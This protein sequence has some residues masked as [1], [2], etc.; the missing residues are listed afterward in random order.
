M[1]GRKAGWLS[2]LLVAI[3]VLAGCGSGGGAGRGEQARTEWTLT[4]TDYQFSPA[5]VVVP[6]GQT[7]TI[8]LVNNSKLNQPHEFMVGRQV[9]KGGAGDSRPVGYETD[10]FADISVEVA[11]GQGLS[12]LMAGQALVTGAAATPFLQAGMTMGGDMGPSMGASETGHAAEE[13]E[14]GHA[15]E[16]AEH[17]ME[18]AEA[19]HATDEA[20][21]AAAETAAHMDEHHGFMVELAAGGEATIRFTVPAD[22]TGE[23]ELGCFIGDGWHYDEGMHGKLIVQG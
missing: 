23:W 15:A 17:A 11:D 2:L 12:M 22:R 14:A 1:K 6:A 8:K 18:K 21:H 7:V 9:A 10:F 16:E 19:G 3:L 20:E 5:T 4:L 13:A